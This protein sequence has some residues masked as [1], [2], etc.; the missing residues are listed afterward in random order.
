MD[1][2]TSDDELG[3]IFA[4][5]RTQLKR[6]AHRILGD[7]HL[8][9]DLVHDAYLRAKEM[10]SAQATFAQPLSYVHRMVRNLAIDRYRRSA[11]ESQIFEPEDSG[12]QVAAPAAR[13]PEA[14][15]ID[16]QELSLVARALAELPERVRRVFELYRLEGRT[17]REIGAELGL[18]AATVN[19]LIREA[20][21]RCR[22]A[23]RTA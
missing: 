12:A 15:A 20:L 21:D 19:T 23:L 9:E 13:T 1:L 17:Q 14:M 4:K 3:E 16:R 2:L 22:A 18:S 8:A 11:L 6:A 7:P 10:T 5:H